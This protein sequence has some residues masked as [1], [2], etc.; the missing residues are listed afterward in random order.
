MNVQ[1]FKNYTHQGLCR[2]IDVYNFPEEH[3]MVTRILSYRFLFQFGHND[4][5]LCPSKDKII[6]KLRSQVKYNIDNN[7][8]ENLRE[9]VDILLDYSRKDGNELLTYLRNKQEENARRIALQNTIKAPVQEGPKGTI[10]AD[11][12]S[13]H[14]TSITKTIKSVS[15]YLVNKYRPFLIR[16]SKDELEF[17]N[18][19][20]LKLSGNLLFKDN[21]QI[22]DTVLNRIYSD[23]TLFEGNQSDAIFFSLWNYVSKQN[24]EELYSRVAEEVFGMY[25][26]CSTRILSGIVNAIQGF[27]TDE[28]LIIKM[29]ESEQYKTI[30]YHYMD[31]Y[32]KNTKDE[33]LLDSMYEKSEYFRSHIRNLIDE[34]RIDWNLEYGAEF[35]KRLNKLVNIYAVCEIFEDF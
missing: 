7:N 23:N 1:L 28:N 26:N 34:K 35:D 22:L 30:V 10:Y 17:K 9:L 14:N 8:Q 27:T 3:P 18:S 5:R 29:D 6:S 13:V 32:L 25:R 20:H 12:Q 33:N 15:R 11:T 31:E 19:I 24:N 4:R 2:A 21:T 16:G